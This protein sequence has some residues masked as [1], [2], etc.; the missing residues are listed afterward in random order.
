MK[1]SNGSP[2]YRQ[3]LTP[4]SRRAQLLAAF[5]RS[6]LS[7]AAFA[8]RHGIGYS[9][10]CAW[11]HRRAKTRPSPAFVQVEVSEPIAPG[12]LVIELGGQ[13]RVRVTSERQIELAV[14]LIQRL[15]TPAAC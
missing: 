8:R 11:R 9:T 12:E 4:A 7:A 13:A 3:R 2:R 14:R 1:I 6:G 10:L 5:D 15:H